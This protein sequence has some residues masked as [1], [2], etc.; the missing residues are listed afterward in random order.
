MAKI[1]PISL[2]ESI[3]GKLDKDENFVFSKRYGNTHVW[4]VEPSEKDPTPGQ[5]AQQARFAQAASQAAEDMLDL[6][7]KAEWQA[8]A[9]A[10][11][12]KWKTA[13]GVAF[14]SYYAQAATE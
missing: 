12:G 5:L 13:R 11:N 3:H 6:D 2:I 8:I 7:K 1:V 9:E 14:A 10:S 4:E